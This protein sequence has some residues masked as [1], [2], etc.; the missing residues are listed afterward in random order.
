MPRS[1]LRITVDGA[2]ILSTLY[3]LICTYLDTD[4][5]RPIMGV[6]AGL[7]ARPGR[8]MGHAGAWI[9]P[10]EPDANDKEKALTRA[11]VVMVD[12]PEKFGDGMKTLL[13]NRAN[14]H[15]TMVSLHS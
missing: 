6:V 2:R 8:I 3:D 4:E 7:Q 9:A 1:G 15:S 11:G 14:G 12:H 10:G 13:S 5:D